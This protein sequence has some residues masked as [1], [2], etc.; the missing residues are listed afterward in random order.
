MATLT[1]A[2][3]VMLRHVKTSL[4]ETVKAI[5]K[6]CVTCGGPYPYYECLAANGN[7]FNASAAA[8]TYNQNQGYRPQ[9][10]SI[11]VL[12]TNGPT[13]NMR[14]ELKKEM[15]TTLTRQNN[16]FKNE[17]TNDIK[18]MISSFF[19]MNTTSSSVSG[20]LPSN[21]VAN[22]RGDLKAITTQSGI[23]YD[24]PPI[25]PPF[26]PLPKVVEQEP[27]VTKDTVQP[28][29]ENIQ[30]TVV[31]IQAS[32]D[33]PVVAPKPKPFIPYPS[34]ANK[35]KLREK[36][37]NLASKFL[38]RLAIVILGAQS[39][40]LNALSIWRKLSLPELTPTRM[41]LELAD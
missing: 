34:R 10:D 33:E 15:D 40:N 22:P 41:I 38:K 30:P 12:A 5:S 39:L 24:G 32:F 8:A 25:L 28:S 1:D 13:C 36:D 31:Q 20:S 29:T 6:S 7:T 21:T 2:I 3:N 14:T 19:Q 11:I 23:S 4:S 18:N 37:N 35:Q 17:L 26:S 9:G 27:E 16:E